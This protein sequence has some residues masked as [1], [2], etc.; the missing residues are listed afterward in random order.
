MKCFDY[1]LDVKTLLR[2]KKSVR[3]EL[4]DQNTDWIEKKIAVLGGSTTAE[5]VDQLELALM[6]AGIKA[7]FYQSEY[8]KYFEDAVFGNSRLDAFKPDVVYIHT[9]WRNILR[10]PDISGT[11]EEINE[12]LNLEYNRFFQ[13]WERLREK[14]RCPVIQNN[15]ERPD[16]R[17]FGNRDIWDSRGRSC[18]IAR[19]NQKFYEYA[20]SVSSFFINDIDY[21]AQDMGLSAWSSPFY[22]NMYRY[23]CSLEAVPHLAA[24]V[25]AIVKSLFGRNKKLL[26]LDLDNTL[27]GGVIGDDGIDGIRI[28]TEIPEG[29]IY[30]AFQKYCH[31]LRKIG[32]VLAVNS[33]NDMKNALE[34]LNHPDSVLKEDDFVVIKANWESKDNNLRSIA[35]E[36]SLG[37]DSIVFIDDNPAE[38]EIVQKNIPQVAVPQVGAP[39]DFISVLDHSWYFE[40]TA[41]S[42][43]DGE[44]TSQYR[45]RAAAAFLK[46][47]FSD[48]NEY[49]ASLEMKAVIT[50]FDPV[51]IQRIAQLTNKTN[52]FN[53]TTLRCT[54]D[55]ITRM[56]EDPSFICL[57]GRLSDKFADHGIVTVVAGEIVENILHIRL[58]LMSCR[59]MKR[60]LEY[61]MMNE[62][63]AKCAELKI[64]EIHGYYFPT[65]K[66]T[67]VK[68]FFCDQGFIPCS[69]TDSRVEEWRIPVP[70][71]KARC[72]KI[73]INHM[74]RKIL[75]SSPV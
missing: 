53:L 45:A 11:E 58:W 44:R 52:Q 5:V 14:F 6:N 57:C 63:V 66:N 48:Y 56:Q 49:L 64:S 40:T 62:L 55:D 42:K 36:L 18:F 8:G 4:L 23:A 21:L 24:S 15:F 72:I 69:S 9:T 32:V 29:R 46:N 12:L 20:R 16:Y 70:S 19:L 71:Y 37:L 27:W 74:S 60:D 75:T 67:M 22:W 3:K 38:R 43:E 10:F 33:K 1:P 47:S 17:L 13:M 73:S 34:G 26:V 25:A 2:R 65:E 28:G 68:S 50:D 54:E 39:E 61:L 35:D 7:Q 51:S 41:L 31:E 30:A 59:V